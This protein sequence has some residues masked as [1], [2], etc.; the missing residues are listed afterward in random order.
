MGSMGCREGL[1]QLLPALLH[2][3]RCCYGKAARQEG[4]SGTALVVSAKDPCKGLLYFSL[5]YFNLYL[6]LK[7]A[8][9]KNFS[10]NTITFCHFVVYKKTF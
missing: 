6:T 1:W 10:L 3:G 2:S 8:G 5:R 7:V 4:V 9:V